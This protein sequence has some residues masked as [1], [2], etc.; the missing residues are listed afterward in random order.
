MSTT[1]TAAANAPVVALTTPNMFTLAGGGLH[2][3]YTT[4]GIDG[5]PHFTYQDTHRTLSFRGNQIR[6]IADTDV[7]TLVSVTLLM[8]V[9]SGSTTFTVLIPRVNM[10]GEQ[11]V[12][13][14]TDG[15]TTIHRFSII[16]ALNIGQR[17]TY[18]VTH[19]SGS[20]SHVLFLAAGAQSGKA[21]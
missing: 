8:T 21:A 2:V 19:L 4:T 18:T 13:I 6:V 16:P 14:K 15:I 11:S 1:Q 12:P 9:D 3:S 7:G 10:V 20:A 5:Q 17:D